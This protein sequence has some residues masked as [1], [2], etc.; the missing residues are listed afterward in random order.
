MKI[1]VYNST[2]LKASKDKSTLE[3]ML[4]PFGEVGYTNKGKVTATRGKLKAAKNVTLNVEHDPARPIGTAFSLQESK[5]GI[6][7]GFTVLDTAAGREA[8]LEASAGVRS[9]LSIE[10]ENPIIRE[11]KILGGLITG[12]ALVARPAFPTAVLTASMPDEGELEEVSTDLEEASTQLEEVVELLEQA[13][14]ITDPEE[15]PT[16]NTDEK[17]EIPMN[18]KQFGGLLSAAKTKNDYDLN[19]LTANLNGQRL[20]DRSLLASLQNITS[21]NILG[22]DQPQYVGELW[23]GKAYE[24]KII[25]L[26]NHAELSSMK[27]QGWE[28]TTEPTVGDYVGGLT[29]IPTSEIATKAIE[30]EAKRLAGGHKLDRKFRDFPNP[31]F[32]ESYLRKMTEAYAK[33]SDAV[34]LAAVKEI[35]PKVTAGTKPTAIAQGLVS[36]VDGA[37][38]ILNET[39]TAPTAALVAPDLWR[40]IVLT[41]QNDILGYLNASLSLEDG[42]LGSFPIVPSAQL[43]KGETLVIARPAVTVHELAGSPIRVE[44]IDVALGGIDSAVFGYYA[45]NIHDKGGLA[46]VT[47][48]A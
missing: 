22:I 41:P 17:E 28:Y 39:D 18:A 35:A 13:E 8:L 45:V 42:T 5:D 15:T 20:G 14:E 3:G 19:W 4:L 31:E 37:I 44:A 12:A 10:I 38:S 46:L 21:S 48:E 16:T 7:A 23:N 33:K 36:I 6:A 1:Q 34:V 30:I 2:M 11:G 47:A 32:W 26:F 29:E 24:R 9:S 27:V 25:P 43:G 40:E